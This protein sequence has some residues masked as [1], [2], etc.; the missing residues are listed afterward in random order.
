MAGR[1]VRFAP[2]DVIR[3]DLGVPVGS[4][5]GFV[6]PAVVAVVVSARDWLD[7]SPSSI[8]AV[9]LTTT[10]RNYPSNVEVAPDAFNGLI[11]TS[12][13]Q[14]EL[15]R[16][17]SSERVIEVSGNTGPSIVGALRD[18]AQLLLDLRT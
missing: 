12:Y 2:G 3:V 13:A 8:F 1:T 15:L 5:G 6:R 17:I 10:K 11:Q 18:I 9:P 7:H 14:V 4:E 16:S